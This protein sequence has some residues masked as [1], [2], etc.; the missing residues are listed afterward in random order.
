MCR[1]M[2]TLILA[3]LLIAVDSSA[4]AAGTRADYETAYHQA[5]AAHK[6][7][8]AIENQWTTTDEVL[9]RA[10]VA[11]EHGRYKKATALAHRAEALAQRSVEQA[12]AQVQVWNQAVPR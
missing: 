1:Y 2:M 6:Q 5:L 11:A 4:Y 7:A 3:V 10:Q 12:K 9:A 8:E